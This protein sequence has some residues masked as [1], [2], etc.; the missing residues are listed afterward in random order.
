MQDLVVCVGENC[1]QSGA[2]L[3]L[4]S[5][6]D[7]IARDD[8][9]NSI[10]LKASFAIGGCCDKDEVTVVFGEHRFQVKPLEADLSFKR[11]ILP[12]LTSFPEA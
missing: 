11:E 3:V 4:R 1:H 10:C 8:L 5:F 7:L 9:E 12:S 6:M 2:E